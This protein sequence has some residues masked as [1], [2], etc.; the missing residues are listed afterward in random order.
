MPVIFI[1]IVSHR[2]CAQPGWEWHALRDELGWKENRCR[3][4]NVASSAGGADRLKLPFPGKGRK[5]NL[6][7]IGS[8][9]PDRRTPNPQLRPNRPAAR[10]VGARSG[11]A[12]RPPRVAMAG[13]RQCGTWRLTSDGPPRSYRRERRRV[14][15]G[16]AAP[17]VPLSSSGSDDRGGAGEGSTVSDGGRDEALTVPGHRAAMP[18]VIVRSLVNRPVTAQ[19]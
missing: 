5:V 6:P 11:G 13:V 1:R 3:A 12:P 8:T 9:R 15:I 2:L 19:P 17:V 10:P 4:S 16:N 7:P 18:L 14:P